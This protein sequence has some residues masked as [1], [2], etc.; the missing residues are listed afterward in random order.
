MCI[1]MGDLSAVVREGVT[2]SAVQVV[3]CPQF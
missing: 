2:D 1:L 3:A